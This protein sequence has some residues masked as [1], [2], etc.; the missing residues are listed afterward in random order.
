[1]TSWGTEAAEGAVAPH[2]PNTLTTSSPA[3][4]PQGWQR[5]DPTIYAD[6]NFVS[7]QNSYPERD[8]YI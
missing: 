8:Y 1:M 6:I 5:A 2:T 3:S 4:T 7:S